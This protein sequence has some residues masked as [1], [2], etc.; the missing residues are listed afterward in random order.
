MAVYVDALI[1]FDGGVVFLLLHAVVSLLL[2]CPLLKSS[3][4]RI[5]L[6]PHLLFGVE[7][8]KPYSSKATAKTVSNNM[9]LFRRHIYRMRYTER[10]GS[11]T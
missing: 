5:Y 1:Q 10:K 4:R 3:S 6:G 2:F 11:C 7:W 8:Q 9:T